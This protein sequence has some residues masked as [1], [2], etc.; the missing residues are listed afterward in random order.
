MRAGI[1]QRLA[2]ELFAE[3]LFLRI[4]FKPE[5][6]DRAHAA[7]AGLDADRA[8]DLLAVHDVEMPRFA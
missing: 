7:A 3:T 1:G 6:A 4:I 5:F 2:D 8:N